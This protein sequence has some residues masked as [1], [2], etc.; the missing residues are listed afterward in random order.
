M[1]LAASDYDGTLFRRGQV[2]RE[3]LAAIAA[4]R[5]RGHLFGL[6]T[7]RDLNLIR[8]EISERQIPYD[9]LICDTGAGLY[10]PDLTPIHL[11]ALPPQAAPLVMDHPA[12]AGSLYRLFSR[13]G[14]TYLD[15]RSS[16]SWLTGLGLPLIP[17]EPEE[18][19]K[20]TGLQQIGLEFSSPAEAQAC[21]EALNRD[22]N[23]LYAQQSSF[24]VDIIAAGC[25]KGAGLK[26]LLELKGWRPEAVLTVGDSENDLSMFDFW[27]QGAY[28]MADATDQVRA[29]AHKVVESP[30]AM[31][32]DN[33]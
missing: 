24:C 5:S 31:L 33:L 19:R 32:W 27:P 13:Y 3:D 22:F 10:G 6:A 14:K 7:G 17:I 21:A 4:W 23:G 11:A 1:K 12:T 8:D 30:A 25:S 20:M 16:R 18:A 2:S 26:L 29:R 28:V 15:L 9:F